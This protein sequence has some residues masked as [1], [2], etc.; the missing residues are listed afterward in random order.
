MAKIGLQGL[1]AA[2]VIAG[3]SFAAPAADLTT[4]RVAVGGAGCLC[5]LPTILAEQIGAY[6]KHGL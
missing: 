1:L 3:S 6:Q 2:A 5:Y 4:I